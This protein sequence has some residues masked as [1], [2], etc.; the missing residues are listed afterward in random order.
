M[1]R[2][3]RRT[4]SC[5]CLRALY[6]LSDCLLC[7]SPTNTRET[8]RVWSAGPW[9][10]RFPNWERSDI[11]LDRRGGRRCTKSGMVCC[12]SCSCYNCCDYNVSF[13]FS[14]QHRRAQ[15][16]SKRKSISDTGHVIEIDTEE[17]HNK[18]SSN[19]SDHNHQTISHTD[20][21]DTLPTKQPS[22]SSSLLFRKSQ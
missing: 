4:N 7:H 8:P 12:C 18:N 6:F 10:P 9:W 15:H 1:E 2:R 5:S 11:S 13:C 17:Q 22:E 21:L 3:R 14:P 20:T 19:S 16:N